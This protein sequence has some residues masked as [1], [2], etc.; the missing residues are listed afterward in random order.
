[1][2][3]LGVLRTAGNT[4]K[5]VLGAAYTH[6]AFLFHCRSGLAVYRWSVFVDNAKRNL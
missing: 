2:P 4:Q 1:M 6:T 5:G 3:Q